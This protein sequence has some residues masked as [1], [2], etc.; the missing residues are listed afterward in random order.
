MR[1]RATLLFLTLLW[2]ALVAGGCT[3]TTDSLGSNEADHLH[4][5]TKPPPAQYPNVLHDVLGLSPMAINNKINAVYQQ[6]FHG[7][8]GTQAIYVGP[9]QTAGGGAPVAGPDEA[10]IYDVLHGQIRSEGIGLGMMIEVELGQD[11]NRIEFENLWRYAKRHLQGMGADTGYFTSYCDSPDGMT[12]T[13]CF[14]P[15]GLEQFLTAL[16][17]AH[18]RWST[19]GTID[20]QADAL[21]L[22]H[23]MRFKEQDVGQ[24]A[25]VTNTF[26]ATTTLP[27]STP[28]VA[29]AGQTRPSIVMPAYY[30]IW[31]EAANDPMFTMAAASGRALWGAAANKTTG[32]LPIRSTFAGA[33]VNGWA[34]FDPEAY[35]NQINMVIDQSWTN[36]A[37][38]QPI[39]D[40]MLAFFTAQGN[41]GTSYTIDGTSCTNT[42]HEPSLVVTNAIA[43]AITTNS[44]RAQYLMTFWNLMVPIGNGRYY[45]G[46]MQL[47]GLLILSGQFQII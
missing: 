11:S 39:V 25:G 6:L 14:D 7:D 33:A 28:D 46:I 8:L 5:V 17:F 41:Y 10:Y 29:S 34:I 32:L 20:Y 23:T 27:F 12:N 42:F 45:P 47:M 21:A 4:P 19:I 18:D 26:D 9:N 1:L 15:Y 22:L 16:I 30:T 13:S 36:A 37:T 2:P 31:A 3:D 43:A 38:G 35:R 44:D 40:K 24:A